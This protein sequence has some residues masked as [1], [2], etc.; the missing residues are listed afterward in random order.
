MKT[1]TMLSLLVIASLFANSGCQELLEEIIKH[2]G[3]DHP[4]AENPADFREVGQIALGTE[5]AAEITAYDPTTK[6]L[7]VV[8][9]DTDSRI[10]VVD[11]HDPANPT[12]LEA[13][14]ITPYGGGANSVAVSDGLLAVAVEADP[15]QDPGLVVF[16][17]TDDLHEV[18]RVSVG[19]LP[20][21]VTFSPDGRYAL[22]ANEGE[23]SDEY[24]TDPLG[25]VSIIDLDHD[26]AVT[27][28]DFSAFEGQQ[29][30]L[31]KEGLRVFGPGA[32][33]AQDL[34]PEYIA[35]SEDSRYAWVSL[36]ENN[37]LARIDLASKT[38]AEIFP[39]GFKDYSLSENAIDVSDRDDQIQLN[40]WPVF[41]MY[42]PDAIAAYEVDGVSYVVTANE[43][44]ARDYDGF[45]EEERVEDL[46]LDAHAFPDANKLQQEDQL[47]RLEITTTLGNTDDDE[48]YEKL[49]SYGAR[50]FSIWDGLSGERVY[51]SGNE[52]EKVVIAA[53]RYA[54]G[55]S[56]A[57]GVE[58][59]GV[60][61]GTIGH[62]TIAF[63][64]LE[65]VDAV[66]VYDVTNPFAPQFLQLL[67]S[68]DAPEGLVFVTADDSP[69]GKSLFIVS[70]E[71][72]GTV[73]LF[74]P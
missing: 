1:R 27:T 22:S 8:S 36:Q 37:G 34:E 55:R 32:T 57:K 48:A 56:D 4:P 45:S 41:G 69:N 40:P 24:D 20:D 47:G 31:A 53:G 29:A 9:N 63:I 74:Q 10:D 52:L 5:G 18:R 15:A 33:L 72:D 67:E 65:R 14:D 16:F 70:S 60:V 71:D 30:H 44:D 35:V 13:I 3:G 61:L 11:L 21:M 26:F 42:Q 51:D 73:K 17:S 54:D 49:Y 12:L 25:T 39:L 28:L 43:G 2:R 59:E 7:F 62:Q 6:K 38:I 68:G 19:A 64:G 66:A 50:S 46:A 58:P 23:P